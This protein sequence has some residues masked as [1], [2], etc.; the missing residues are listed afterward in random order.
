MYLNE[1]HQ[2]K[3]KMTI[4]RVYIIIIYN[5]SNNNIEFIINDKFYDRLKDLEEKFFA[6]NKIIY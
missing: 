3:S 2:K 5:Y 1:I 4:F 6:I